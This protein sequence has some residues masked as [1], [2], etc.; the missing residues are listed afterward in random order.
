MIKKT[1]RR[2]TMEEI[3]RAARK[4]LSEEGAV[5]ITSEAVRQ[6]VQSVAEGEVAE[7][8]RHSQKSPN[9]KD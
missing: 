9:G 1:K 7:S 2:P 3:G 5:E 4:H 8:V 6:A